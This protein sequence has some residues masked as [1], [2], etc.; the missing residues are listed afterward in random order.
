MKKIVCSLFVLSSACGSNGST[1]CSRQPSFA[2]ATTVEAFVD[3]KFFLEV[4]SDVSSDQVSGTGAPPGISL[5]D[6][7]ISG[8]PTQPGTSAIT[9][10]VESDG[11]ICAAEKSIEFVVVENPHNC[12]TTLDCRQLLTGYGLERPCTSTSDCNTEDRFGGCVP[13]PIDGGGAYCDPSVNADCGDGLD[14]MIVVDAEGNDVTICVLTS[15]IDATCNERNNC[16]D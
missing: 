15:S 1:E 5:E 7:S 10:A 3:G 6:G 9:F 13:L 16:I 2:T 8:V 11:D 14:A 12:A 4:V